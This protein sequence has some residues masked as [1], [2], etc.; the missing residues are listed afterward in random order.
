MKIVLLCAL[1]LAGTAS[2][3]TAKAKDPSR[4][5]I[6]VTKRGFEPETISVAANKP[7]ILVFTRKTEATCAKRVVVK[8]GGDKKVEAVLP[9]DK[10]V[11]VPVTFAKGGTL[12][13]ACTM[14]MIKGTIQVQ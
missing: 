14:D 13:Y 4:I 12:T 2:A 8:L 5:E 7:L 1:A 3:D 6:V 11:E 10:A 9:L